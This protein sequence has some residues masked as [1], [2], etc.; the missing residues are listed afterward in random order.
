MLYD[1]NDSGGMR[2]SSEYCVIG[3]PCLVMRPNVGARDVEAE[4]YTGHSFVYYIK[5]L[6]SASPTLLHAK[7]PTIAGV[8]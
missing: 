4:E 7:G 1:Y 6:C 2:F 8:P 5:G 3:N